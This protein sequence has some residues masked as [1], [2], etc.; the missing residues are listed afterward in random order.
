MTPQRRA[1]IVA[2]ASPQQLVGIE[3]RPDLVIAADSGLHAVL[4]AGWIPDHL[5]GDLDSADPSA[6]EIAAESGAVVDRHPVGKDKT[7]LELA[8][9]AAV[10]AGATEIRVVVRADG[11]LDHQ[12]A[13]V[14]ALAKPDWSAAEVR[15][16][17][18]D[19]VVWVVR[20]ERRLEVEV[21]Q[22]L[23]LLPIGG[24]ARVTTRGVAFP[25]TDE[26]LSPF[27]GRGIANEATETV[28]SLT[29]SDGVVL[30]VSSPPHSDH[31]EALSS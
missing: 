19:H 25:L 16:D 13:N 21:G 4:A 28:V 24:P 11:R 7:D 12:L 26:V 5:V 22:H 29:V 10:D 31:P 30:V 8:L 14:F 9:A 6:V 20:G 2:A 3:T 17:I 23:A 18:G 15:A 1:L 27:D